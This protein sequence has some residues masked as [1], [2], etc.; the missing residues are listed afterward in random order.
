MPARGGNRV[1]SNM[2]RLVAQIRGPITQRAMAE[3]LIIIEGRA[4]NLTP[5]D[6]SNLV[7]SRFR[8]VTN[9]LTGTKGV[10]GYTAAYALYVHEASGKLRGRPRDPSKPGRGNFWDTDADPHFLAKGAE[11][12]LPEVGAA[13]I[14]NYRRPGK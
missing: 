13:I 8:Q 14:R 4:V 3:I 1:R 12:A 2:R 9:T 7:N 6:T 11:E 10:I 5:V